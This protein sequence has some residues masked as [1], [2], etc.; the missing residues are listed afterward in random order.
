MEEELAAETWALYL[1]P[2]KTTAMTRRVP[3]CPFRVL[4]MQK[5]LLYRY[6]AMDD[7]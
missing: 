1:V 4:K 2:Q 3:L 5:A 7:T 6:T